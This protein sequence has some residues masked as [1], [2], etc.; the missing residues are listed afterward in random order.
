MKEND[1]NFFHDYVRVWDDGA[2][3]APAFI[4]VGLEALLPD[5]YGNVLDAP[6]P[7]PVRPGE[8]ILDCGCGWGRVLKPVLDRGGDAVGCDISHNMLR[9]ARDHLS[10]YNHHAKLVRGDATN[11]PFADESF[12]TV[13]C[14][15]VL[16]H[17]SKDNGIEVLREISRVLKK[18]GKAYIRVPSRFSPENLLFAFLQFISIHVFRL[19]DPIRMRFYRI[20][21]IKKICRKF[22]SHCEITAHEFRPPW[23]FHTRI[24]WH[25]IIIP[26]FLHRPL[27]RLS[28]KIEKLANGKLPFLK[29]F[30]VT[31]MIHLVK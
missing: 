24:S 30:G 11:L 31:L 22:F 28:D 6:P 19:H 14:L 13:Y 21:E 1:N 23:N 2:T 29:H 10:K 5:Y 26:R 7:F 12:D 17:L 4:T 8:R 25:I 9:A 3:R 20:G 27:R 15:L 18:G 16:Q